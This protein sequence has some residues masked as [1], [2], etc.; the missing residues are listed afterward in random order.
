M[1]KPKRPAS[2]TDKRAEKRA[3]RVERNRIRTAKHVH[4][5]LNKIQDGASHGF[6]HFNWEEA[7]DA[8][9]QVSTFLS[10]NEYHAIGR[11]WSD[12]YAMEGVDEN[13]QKVIELIKKRFVN[14][15][16]QD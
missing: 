14:N 1:T 16:V 4:R 11:A 6:N 10:P 3:E 15:P 7:A 13:V 2:I 9:A 5:L 12:T 8:Y